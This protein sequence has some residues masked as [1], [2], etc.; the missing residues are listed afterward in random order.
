MYLCYFVFLCRAFVA[1]ADIQVFT[2]EYKSKLSA[3]L[4]GKTKY[5]TQAVKEICAAFDEFQNQKTSGD[6]TDDSR[7]GSEAPTVDEAV[8]NSKDTT[9]AVTSHAEKDNIYASNAGSDSED[10]LQKTRERGSLDEQ[11][12]ESGRPNDSSSVSSPLV[13]SKLSTGSEIKKN[14]SK[15][16]LKSASN[17]NDFGQH[18]NGNSVLTNGS[19]PRKLVTG[20]KRRLEV[21]DGR[22]KNGGSSAGTILKV[23]SSIGSADLSRSGATFKTGKKGK[24][25]SAGKSD[26]PDTLKPDLN[27]NTG[28]KGKN[29]ISKNATLEVKNELP[30]IMSDA[31]EAGG[32]NLSM[33]KKNQVHTKHNVGANE[34][35]H[36]A[37]KLKRMDAK[38]DLTSG[39]IP[40]N[41]KSTL[42]CSTFVEDKSSK[43]F[44]LKRSTSNSKAE[45]SSVRELPPTIKHHSQVQKTMPDSDRIASDEKKDWSNL[46]LK[47]DMKN[48]MTKQ[49]QKKRKAVC[50]Y[51]DDDKPKTPVHGGAAKNSKSPFA[52]DVKK[53]NNA[54]SEKSDA[55]HL[56]LRNSSE[57]V[58]AHLKESS[59]QLHSHTSS[60]KPSQKEKADEII[61]VHVPHS[62]D[63]LDSKQFPSKAAKVSSAS[64]VKSPQAVPTITKSNAERSKSSKPL[65]KASSIATPKKADNGSSKSS[66][67]LSSSQNQVSAHK[68]LSSSAEI[69]K[70][71]P[72]TLPQAVDIPMSAVDFKEPDALHVDR[73][74]CFMF[75]SFCLVLFADPFPFLFLFFFNF[76]LYYYR[77]EEGMEERSNMKH[78]IAAAQ[79]KW[80]KAHSQ[81]LSSDIH[82]VQGETPSPSTVQPFLSVSSNF[83]HADVQGVHEH[84][85]SVSPLTN[86]YHSASQNQLDADEIEERRVS[87]VQRGPG[88]SLSGGTEAAVARDAF[89][90][91]IETLSRTK[92]SIGRATR[93]AIDCAKYGIANEVSPY[94]C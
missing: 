50:L 25:A 91:M 89:E 54:H 3:R 88:G 48:V 33:G 2:S 30:E 85:T 93:L 62:H 43:M 15:P 36:A 4:H 74:L 39:H 87:S 90:G 17:V 21:A 73:Y 71:T 16:T 92:E 82:H 41:V 9:D 23:G 40:K 42:P 7:I 47:G 5:F 79:A 12:T 26:S 72:K 66:H 52:S 19:T 6:D 64:P 76:F 28:E 70:T 38:D 34:S 77:L 49:V 29:L 55:A 8:G 13:K 44:E 84:T 81:Y 60:I 32:K 68:K 67:N 35:L 20:S 75:F 83:A 22:N 51:E 56:A 31:K 58:D 24:D 57:H 1:P 80:K 53:G 61:T 14:S 78:L 94:Y 46:K 63:K 27:G 45:K 10:C 65:L 86:E 59:S 18:D 69:S 11:L 37:K